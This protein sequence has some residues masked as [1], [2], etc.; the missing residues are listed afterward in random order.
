MHARIFK[1]TY[2]NK[3]F[4]LHLNLNSLRA[5]ENDICNF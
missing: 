5:V 2:G 4:K 3:V 1:E